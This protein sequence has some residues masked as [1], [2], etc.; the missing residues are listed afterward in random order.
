MSLLFSKHLTR[1]S[2]SLVHYVAVLTILLHFN[3]LIFSKP[4]TIKPFCV[5]MSGFSHVHHTSIWCA[6]HTVS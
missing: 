3:I 1:C 2:Q 6:I 4:D 5:M